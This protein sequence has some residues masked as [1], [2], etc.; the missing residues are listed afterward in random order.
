[1]AEARS[2]TTDDLT[3]YTRGKYALCTYLYVSRGIL[4]RT[5]CASI[6]LRLDQPC[7]QPG[8]GTT[9]GGAV[10]IHESTSV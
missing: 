8:Y 2:G 10:H 5:L 6:P 9:S 4:C 1:M 3:T 7:T